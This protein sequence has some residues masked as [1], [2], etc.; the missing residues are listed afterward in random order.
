MSGS[1][2]A[3]TL[4]RSIRVGGG[5]IRDGLGVVERSIH[6]GCPRAWPHSWRRTLQMTR[7]CSGPS[8][9]P[10]P[11]VEEL[12]EPVEHVVAVLL[13]SGYVAPDRTEVVGSGLG[14]PRARD[15][16]LELHHPYVAFGL[17]VVERDVEVCGEAEHFCPTVAQALQ[18]TGGRGFYPLVRG[19]DFCLVRF[20]PLVQQVLVTEADPAHRGVAEAV[21]SVKDRPGDVLF[22]VYEQVDH[23]ACPFLAL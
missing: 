7:N 2:Q 21:V 9:Q 5:A 4:N 11:A 10:D 20:P 1:S 12:A 23:L 3:T 14:A 19:S 22:R 17:V 13:H 16:L 6:E 15:L 18:E 8:G